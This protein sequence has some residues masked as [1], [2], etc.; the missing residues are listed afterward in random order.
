M[1]LQILSAATPK[2]NNLYH[3]CTECTE[4]KYDVDKR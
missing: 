1:Q 3:T 4:Y 2:Y